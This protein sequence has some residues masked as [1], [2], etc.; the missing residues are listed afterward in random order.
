[1][2]KQTSEEKRIAVCA[3]WHWRSNGKKTSSSKSNGRDLCCTCCLLFQ[4]CQHFAVLKRSNEQLKPLTISTVK[5][6]SKYLPSIYLQS[7]KPFHTIFRKL[8]AFGNIPCEELSL[9]IWFSNVG[10]LWECVEVRYGQWTFVQDNASAIYRFR[11]FWRYMI[12]NSIA[13]LGL[14]LFME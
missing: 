12:C 10:F 9:V 1:M 4:Y 13:R 6:L 5:R 2:Y 8:S 11:H 3:R 14:V 7:N